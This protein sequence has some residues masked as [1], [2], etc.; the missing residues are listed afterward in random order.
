[1]AW[2][3]TGN[4]G[5]TPTNDFLGTTDNQPLVIKTNKAEA[6]RINVDPSKSK[7]EIAAQDGLAISGF[8]PFLTL[9]DANAASA[10][11]VVQG[12]NGDLVFIPQS[13]IGSGA[14]MVVKT[15]SGNV[16]IGTSEPSSK[17]EIV[18]QDGLAISE[19]QPFLT[20]RDANAG[21]ARSVVQGVNGDLVFI[22]HSFIGSGAAM[23]VKTN[24]GNV[25]IG[26]SNPRSK[27]DR[28]TGRVGDQRFSAIPDA[29]G[30]RRRQRPE[31]RPRCRG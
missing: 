28:R 21:N 5:P 12:V 19:Y 1:M 30:C 18:A 9:R 24:S 11:S 27:V 8:Q 20:L 13:F 22:P 29:S 10:R 15:G 16:G 6:L 26:T 3:T 17:V 25:G 2:N 14:A 4:G 23:V 31:C 7:V